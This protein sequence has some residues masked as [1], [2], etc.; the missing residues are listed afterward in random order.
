MINQQR[1][2]VFQFTAASYL[3]RLHEF[4]LY[5]QIFF[6]YIKILVF[7][8]AFINA[9]TVCQ[10][11][12]LSVNQHF[13]NLFSHFFNHFLIKC[14]IQSWFSFRQNWKQWHW[15]HFLNKLKRVLKNMIKNKQT[16][17]SKIFTK[18]NIKQINIFILW[19]IFFIFNMFNW[20][21]FQIFF[22]KSFAWSFIIF[23]KNH[24]KLIISFREQFFKNNSQQHLVT[25]RSEMNMQKQFKRFYN[26]PYS[27]IIRFEKSKKVKANFC[28]KNK[29]LLI[30]KSPYDK[31]KKI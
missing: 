29:L 15:T 30:T 8:K 28:I 19:K 26:M 22:I 31:L 13:Y 21:I 16:Q 3:R 25:I 12:L 11:C 20:F 14:S 7:G 6:V 4:S 24:F 17:Y 1:H 2:T 23:F 10:S 27:A 18:W 9:K 5:I